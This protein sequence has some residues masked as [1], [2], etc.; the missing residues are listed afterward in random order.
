[1][2][3][4]ILHLADIHIGSSRDRSIE[5]RQVFDDV[6]RLAD[7]LA[8]DQDLAVVICG[9]VF[10]H[11]IKYSPDDID[12]F[13]YF[14][15]ILKPH[16][17]IIIPGNHDVNLNDPTSK[18]LISPLIAGLD[19]MGEAGHVYY[20]K[21][22]G[23]YTVGGINFY[24]ISVCEKH[25]KAALDAQF[26]D[27]DKA[28]LLSKT[29]LLYHGQVDGAT[30]GSWVVRDGGLSVAT[31]SKFGALLLGDIHAHQ[32]IT[33]RAA[34]PGSLIQQN[35]GESSEKGLIHWRLFDDAGQFNPR[36]E[37]IQIS[38]PARFIKVDLRSGVSDDGL[39]TPAPA[40]ESQLPAVADSSTAPIRVAVTIDDND[41]DADKKI[42]HIKRIYG[43]VDRVTRIYH[44]LQID[45]TKNISESLTEILREANA[46]EEDINYII[47]DYL[48]R[49]QTFENK[50]WYIKRMSWSNLFRYGE[51]NVLDFSKLGAGLSGVIA[52]NRAGKS[53]IIDIL[54]FG[55]FNTPLR[56]DI[57]SIVNKS[58]SS[59]TLTVE[60]CVDHTDYVIVRKGDRS[61][62]PKLEFMKINVDSSGKIVEHLTKPTIP[63]TYREI[64]KLIGDEDRFLATGLMYD[65]LQDLARMTKT[66]RLTTLSSLFGLI[67]NTNIVKNLKDK[68]KVE[69]NKL[70]KLIKPRVDDPAAEIEK[71]K[72]DIDK[73]E[74]ETAQRRIDLSDLTEQINTLSAKLLNICDAKKVEHEIEKCKARLQ[75]YH[76]E[77]NAL[78]EQ[79]EEIEYAEPVKLT[80][81]EVKSLENLIS[82]PRPT[83][84]VEHVANEIVTLEAQ[85]REMVPQ[86]GRS[87]QSLTVQKQRLETQLAEAIEV[88]NSAPELSISAESTAAADEL[89]NKI[90]EVGEEI[91]T[92]QK[93]LAPADERHLLDL[94][95]RVTRLRNN[96]KMKFNTA[97]KECAANK[98]IFARDLSVA[99]SELSSAEERYAQAVANN[100][101]IQ[102]LI[103]Q[104]T[105]EQN[106]LNKK[107]LQYA[108]AIN[109]AAAI[110]DARSKID[111]IKARLE[112]L[113]ADISHAEQI[114]ARRRA[115][116]AEL[117][118]LKSDFAAAKQYLD[119][120]QR[121]HKYRRY[122]AFLQCRR[123]KELTDKISAE[124]A[125]LEQ[126]TNKLQIAQQSAADIYQRELLRAQRD[127]LDEKQL[128]AAAE[129]GRLKRELEHMEIELK[130]K[131]E[132][133]A[134][135]PKC[136][137]TINR[138][139]L[140]VNAID[141]V[142]LKM[143][144]IKKYI[145]SLEQ[146]I[147]AILA[148]FTD[149]K[150]KFETSDKEVRIYIEENGQSISV[151]LASGFQRF[152]IS[153]A[154]RL[155]LISILPAAPN[156]LIIDEGF[157]CMDRQNINK[158]TDFFANVSTIL[159][160]RSVFIISHIDE[161]QN[162]IPMP[163]FISDRGGKSHI[164]NCA[165]VDDSPALSNI[166]I[167]NKAPAK[168]P[169]KSKN[170]AVPVEGSAQKPTP[171][172]IGD[173]IKCECGSILS[174]KSMTEHLQSK[175]HLAHIS[176]KT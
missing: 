78:P 25:T 35:L 103:E 151:E 42:E 20:W 116:A 121:L 169:R 1:M 50:K 83:I 9:D 155:V 76:N 14:M 119:A 147:N 159:S 134:E 153:L 16:T 162:V 102:Q 112:H 44:Q 150:I 69:K 45:P 11:K 51:D 33:P 106:E 117:S 71:I 174:K 125:N 123:R 68:I 49:A 74:A 136:K 54:M 4:Q 98:R 41:P 23:S 24:H 146:N 10:H 47:T 152:I 113:A 104:L 7:K 120:E 105:V 114:E 89:R 163:L 167:T 131:H 39:I 5:Y 40:A 142:A 15:N 86:P 143:A 166:D 27:P 96:N 13:Y 80:A 6:K 170:K 148:Q 110:A 36:G 34:Y 28:E 115:I 124:R 19:A 127:E 164:N 58:A 8:R 87:L 160:D 141:G 79:A 171:A 37:F 56:G 63:E 138:Y 139:S 17:V 158:L 165:A 26:N 29:I 57:K 59:Y 61:R 43:R 145:N 137:D 126:L 12:D 90:K 52:P 101:H 75:E 93:Q 73:I 100:K 132:Y 46:S 99:E 140:Y 108:N 175:K 77:L 129:L 149:F 172:A 62:N 97:C 122:N 91:A 48:S 31:Y 157:G 88:V 85:L 67:D 64:K 38:N 144:I 107:F 70:S 130:Y 135:H 2:I 92:L 22:S 30:F 21:E 176:K 55:L 173:R 95:A 94:R 82:G 161:L 168:G 128:S 18:D 118:A 84:D 65:S 81:A 154:I 32:F 109:Q 111:S 72:L 156:F 53:S 3:R 133:D 66:E 60:F